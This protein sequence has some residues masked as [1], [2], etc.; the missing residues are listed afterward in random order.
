MLQGNLHTLTFSKANRGL[1]IKTI[2]HLIILLMNFSKLRLSLDHN[3]V[4][5]LINSKFGYLF[6]YVFGY[7]FGYLFGYYND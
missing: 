5:A 2:T 4:K 1:F 6:D 3:I 7:L